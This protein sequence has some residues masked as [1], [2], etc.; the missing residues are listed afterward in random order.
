M[1]K[2]AKGEKSKR[3]KG[4]KNFT[5]IAYQGID[6]RIV[7][8]WAIDP[9]LLIKLKKYQLETLNPVEIFGKWGPSVVKQH[10][11][12]GVIFSKGTN[13]DFYNDYD[14]TKF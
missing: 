1:E 14:A 7:P 11:D 3:D 2:R 6:K 5:K 4:M 8:R 10:F 9:D 13:A 12:E